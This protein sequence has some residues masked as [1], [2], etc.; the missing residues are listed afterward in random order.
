MNKHDHSLVDVVVQVSCNSTAFLL[1]SGQQLPLRSSEKFFG[2]LPVGNINGASDV[3][4]EGS[5]RAEAR[6]SD[7]QDPAIFL[8]VT[9]Q[10]VLHLKRSLQFESLAISFQTA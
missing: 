10:A 9:T 2:V 5:I 6:N 3:S 4:G 7:V 1:L 8:I